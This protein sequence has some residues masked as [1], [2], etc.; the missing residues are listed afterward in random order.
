LNRIFVYGSLR[1]GTC[2]HHVISRFVIAAVPAH[3]TGE[4]YQMPT[5][6]PM[7]VTDGFG[8]GRVYG[9]IL[10]LE[11]LDEAM[12]LLDRFEDYYG[13]GNANN[14]YE[15]ICA[16]AWHSKLEKETDV[17]VYVCPQWKIVQCKQEG[18]RIV[19]GDW[20]LYLMERDGSR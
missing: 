19:N 2:N 11:R 13:P 4:L 15:R 6:Y 1:R 12:A 7:L 10:H 20:C 18:M 14:E 16:S 3:I 5:G 17:F 9:E 8:P